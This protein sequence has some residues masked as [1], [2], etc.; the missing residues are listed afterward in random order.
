MASELPSLY[1]IEARVRAAL[2]LPLPGAAAHLDLA[3]R[4]RRGR[5]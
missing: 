2:A 3:P 5:E 4:P 1:Q